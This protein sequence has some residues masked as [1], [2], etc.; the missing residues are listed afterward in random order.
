LKWPD[1]NNR[2]PDDPLWGAGVRGGIRWDG[3]FYRDV[4][5]YPA[6]G[7]RFWCAYFKPGSEPGIKKGF[8]FNFGSG[9]CHLAED[10]PAQVLAGAAPRLFWEAG[11]AAPVPGA[12]GGAAGTAATTTGQWK[13]II[14][15]TMFVTYAV[16]EVWTGVKSGGNDPV[17]VYTRVS[18]CDPL[19][20]LTIA[21]V[22]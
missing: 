11:V 17:G 22:S 15:A 20:S 4:S 14:E 1:P 5:R 13:L 16:V 18:G 10:D 19:A 6:G 3:T 9:W 21:A 2:K 7:S 12:S 8:W